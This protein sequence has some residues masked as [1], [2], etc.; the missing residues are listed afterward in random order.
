MFNVNF[1]HVLTWEKFLSQSCKGFNQEELKEAAEEFEKVVKYPFG[2]LTK[3]D[4]EEVLI[5]VD[6]LIVSPAL[7][8]KV[9]K[10]ITEMMQL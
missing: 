3:E 7:Q 10:A 2:I 6:P 9:R 4:L 8:D 5:T 1:T